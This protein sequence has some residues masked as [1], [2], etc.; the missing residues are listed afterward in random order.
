[1][2]SSGVKFLVGIALVGALFTSGAAW[3]FLW[4]PADYDAGFD[5]R[6]AHPSFSG[7]GPI[8]LYDEGHLNVHTANGA[9]RPFTEMLRHDGYDVRVT[10]EPFSSRTLSGAAVLAVVCARGA[11]DANDAPAF[12]EDETAAVEQWVRAG[13]ALLLVSD[14][15]PFGS[16][17]AELARRFGVTMGQGLVED[18]KHHDPQRGASHLIFSAGNGLLRDHP[19]VRGTTPAE[20]IERVLTFTGQSLAGPPGAIAFLALSDDAVEYSPTTPHVEKSGGDVRVN[21]EY[22]EPRSAAG[23]SQGLAMEYG[24]GRVVVLGESGMLRAQREKHDSRVGMNV[25]GYDNRQLALNIMHY[26]H[27][28]VDPAAG[29]R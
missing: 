18:P 16:A 25:P 19:I 21:M 4:N 8:V 24:S 15:W 12:P 9:Y 5:T 23:R 2:S 28:G 26:L 1:M 11:N 29:T 27:G 17:A 7:P 14:H 3:F 20:R 10:K 22:G 13:G 6:V